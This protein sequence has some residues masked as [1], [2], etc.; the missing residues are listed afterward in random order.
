MIGTENGLR[1]AASRVIRALWPVRPYFSWAQARPLGTILFFLAIAVF[2]GPK[3]QAAP[4]IKSPAERLLSGLSERYRNL[5]SFQAQYVRVA[6]TPSTDAIFKSQTSQTA[7]GTLFWKSRYMLR[8]DQEK[9]QTELMT[10]DGHTV[11]W[12]LPQENIVHVYDKL[13]LAGELAPLLDFFSGLEELKRHFRI[14]PAPAEKD[15]PDQRG[16]ILE[17]KNDPEGRLS[18]SHITVWCDKDNALVGFR[19]SSVTGERTDFNLRELTGNPELEDSYF[20]FSPPE[21]VEVIE[22]VPE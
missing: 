12:Y 8:L 6:Y 17:P 7:S 13:D 16:L 15:R 14:K 21:G 20:S 22:E 11:W 18:G 9:P 2:S 1:L 10:T 3:A 19:L 5:S 4:P